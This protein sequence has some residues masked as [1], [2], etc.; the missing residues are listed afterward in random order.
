MTSLHFFFC[1]STGTSCPLDDAISYQAKVFTS[2]YND[3]NYNSSSSEIGDTET[4]GC[5]HSSQ[6]KD[7]GNETDVVIVLN[8]KGVDAPRK[9]NSHNSGTKN[10]QKVRSVSHTAL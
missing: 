3:V 8:D 5:L 1:F 6:N 9:L 7:D 4:F 10:A 2:P